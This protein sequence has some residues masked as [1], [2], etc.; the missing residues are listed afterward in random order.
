MPFKNVLVTGANGYIGN[1]VCKAFVRAGWR[2]YGAVRRPESA[3]PLE[4]DEV[5][6]VVAN[7]P[8]LSILDG[9]F[10]HTKTFDAIIGCTDAVDYEVHFKEALD[11]F[12][13][14]SETSNQNGV[15]PLVLW[16]SGC[17]DYG[18]TDV[19]GAENL[20]PHTE[21]SPLNPPSILLPRTMC[22]LKILEQ[23]DLFDAAV[24]RPTNVFGYSSS[25]YSVMF[26][27]AATEASKGSQFLEVVDVRPKT[28]LHASKCIKIKTSPLEVFDGEEFLALTFSR[29]AC[30]RLRRGV[31]GPG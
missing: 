17:K 23:V 28:I 1:A 31:L 22:S 18:M 27:H 5:I 2:V 9:L 20:T 11:M 25:Y 30:G 21:S 16:S 10:E 19:D 29:S 14:I 13:R 6:P 12:R 15:R 24:L 4:R 26:E 7:L 3:P 8:D